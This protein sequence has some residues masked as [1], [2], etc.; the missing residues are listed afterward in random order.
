VDV[1]NQEYNPKGSQ[2]ASQFIFPFDDAVFDFIFF[3]SVFTHMLP[4]DLENYF[5]EAVRVLKKGGRLFITYFVL[6]QDSL[7]NIESGL[8]QRDF[9]Y[10]G[11]GY[12]TIN[13]DN[14]EAAVAYP[15]AY[16]RKLYD[17][18]GMYI[19]EP[20]RYGSW[21]GR[22]EYFSYQDIIVAKKK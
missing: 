20:I 14:P 18:H 1:Y 19:L 11:S 5:R 4:A 8:S 2:K 15:E 16:I 6:N 22:K 13:S 21:S 7:K 17:A 3:T 10:Q 12:R 9:L